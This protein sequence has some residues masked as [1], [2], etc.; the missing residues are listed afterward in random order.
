VSQ[1]ATIV[2]TLTTAGID[3]AYV[4]KRLA[5]ITVTAGYAAKRVSDGLEALILEVTTSA[6]DAPGDWPQSR[7]FEVRPQPVKTGA[8]HR[9]RVTL[10]LVES[11]FRMVFRALA[12][13]VCVALSREP[14]EAHAIQRFHARLSH[15]QSFLQKHGPDGLS[16]E[17]RCGLYGELYVLRHTILPIADHHRAVQAWRG[18]KKAHQDFQFPHIA[19]EVKTTRADIVDRISVSNIQQLDSDGVAPLFLTV[20]HAQ[21][22][23]T[24][25]ETLPEMIENLR[26]ELEDDTRDLLNE[27]LAEVGYL[28]EHRHLY[29]RTRYQGLSTDHFRVGP[30]FPR[31]TLDQVPDGVKRVKYQISID[32]CRPHQVNDDEIRRALESDPGDTTLS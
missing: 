27:G 25:G 9:T 12:D 14:D 1:F 5:G 13:D 10:Q 11:R 16:Q 20:V 8:T 23:E 31:M 29:V 2:D 21:E 17:A 6:L 32:A 26:T 22:S 15:W 30:G 4:R 28:D 3:G 24:N 19:L 18:C 7:G